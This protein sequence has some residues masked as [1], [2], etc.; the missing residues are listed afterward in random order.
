MALRHSTRISSFIL[1][2]AVGVVVEG[3]P[4]VDIFPLDVDQ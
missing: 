3:Q 4:I 1:V 2:D